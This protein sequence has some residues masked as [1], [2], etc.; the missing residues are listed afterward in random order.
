MSTARQLNAV[1][2]DILEAIFIACLPSDRW[3]TTSSPT[4]SPVLL[5]HVCSRWRTLAIASP[6]LWATLTVKYLTSQEFESSQ[7]D[8][9]PDLFPIAL[10]KR[11]RELPVNLCIN[12]Q[13]VAKPSSFTLTHQII[14]AVG[15]NLTRLVLI[16]NFAFGVSS[17]PIETPMSFPLLESLAFAPY[18]AMGPH[19][20][21]GRLIEAVIASSPALCRVAIGFHLAQLHATLPFHQI[22]HYRHTTFNADSLPQCIR[23]R[24]LGIVLRDMD[25]E[26]QSDFCYPDDHLGL[27]VPFDMPG[28]RSLSITHFTDKCGQATHVLPY[29]KLFHTYNF[30]NLRTLRISQRSQFVEDSLNSLDERFIAKL[31]T[32]TNLR[33]LSLSLRKNTSL[34]MLGTIFDALPTINT[35]HF[36]RE[37]GYDDAFDLLAAR[38]EPKEQEEHGVGSASPHRFLPHLRTICLHNMK[39]RSYPG[40]MGVEAFLDSI[41][42][43][44]GFNTFLHSRVRLCRPE[45][46]LQRL[47]VYGE[48]EDV[49]E[50]VHFAR[51][52]QGYTADGLVFERKARK[53]SFHDASVWM[54]LDPETRGWEEGAFVDNGMVPGEDA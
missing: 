53:E 7:H 6:R 37:V 29:P 8:D 31:C 43:E 2:D 3:C 13:G 20:N 49:A 41:Q 14:A 52:A 44:Y 32:F 35:L 36:C 48:A 26:S 4:A 10:L 50:S 25:L 11:A 18:A 5:T 22:T 21:L 9:A 33:Y 12:I 19:K 34:R 1:P 24:W 28:I 38:L 17:P 40:S 30:P 27:A 47:V 45:H 39:I 42:P 15:K 23:L 46:R 51:C 54:G 16:E